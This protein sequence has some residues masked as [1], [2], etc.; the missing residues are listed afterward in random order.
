MLAGQI[1]EV[2]SPTTLF[3]LSSG[4]EEVFWTQRSLLKDHLEGMVVFFVGGLASEFLGLLF[5]DGPPPMQAP[6]P[7][8]E[9][10]D[11]VLVRFCCLAVE[12]ELPE[13]EIIEDMVT[14][15]WNLIFKNEGF[16]MK[17]ELQKSL[18]KFDED[19][20]KK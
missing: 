14:K 16:A 5:L 9:G 17:R 19:V 11:E 15:K 10:R 2:Y 13:K 12:D 3:L 4:L 8:D 1:E 6:V 20:W 7:V 18:K